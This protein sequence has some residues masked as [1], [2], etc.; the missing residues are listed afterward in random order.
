L[1]V[2][3]RTIHTLLNGGLVVKAYLLTTGVIFALLTVL[4][5]WRMF[6][7]AGGPGRD[8]W[9][10]LITLVAAAFTVWAGVLLRQTQRGGPEQSA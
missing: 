8:P 3:R 7:E 4:H 10:L 2:S 1:S 5:A 9:F 6:A